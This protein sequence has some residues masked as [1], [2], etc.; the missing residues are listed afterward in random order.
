MTGFGAPQMDASPRWTVAR[1]VLLA[2][3]SLS[4][5][6]GVAG[7]FLPLL[8][9]FEFFLLAAVCYGRSSATASRWLTTNRLFGKRLADYREGRGASLATKLATGAALWTSVVATIFLFAAPLWLTVG[10]LAIAAGV[11]VHLITL[12][13]VRR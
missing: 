13:T 2:A 10:L 11:T 6:I 1:V 7:M 8:P 4:V 3:G 12:K 9:S 5:A